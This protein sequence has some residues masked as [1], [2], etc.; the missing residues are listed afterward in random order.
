L[1]Q[2]I[3]SNNIDAR[4]DELLTYAKKMGA[5]AAEVDINIETGYSATARM[6]EAET[7]EYNHDND[8]SIAVYAGQKTGVVSTSDLRP[9]ALHQAVDAALRIAKYTQD[10]PAAGLADK[11]LLAKQVP[12]LEIDFPWALS[13]PEAM[14]LAAECD[15]LGLDYSAKII[16]SDGAT[17][18]SHRSLSAYANSNGFCQH[19]HST[20]HNISSV[21]VGQDGQDMQRD[22]YYYTASD[23]ND[24]PGI[25]QVA[26]LA[27][28]RT[29]QRLNPRQIS[30]GQVPVLFAPEVARGL[31]GHVLSAIHGGALYKKASFLLDKLET[32]IFPSWFSLEEQ[33]HLPKGLGS[34]AFDANGLL[35]YDKFFVEEGIL[36]NYALGIYSA[37]KLKMQSTA[38]AGG[39]HNIIATTGDKDFAAMLKELDTG[40]L[41]TEIVGPGVNTVTGD[42]SRGASGFWVEKGEIQYPFDEVTIAGNLGDIYRNIRCMGNDVDQRGKV[43]C[44][45]IL[46]DGLM[47]A[48]GLA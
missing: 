35:T 29:V 16:N 30:T 47:V 44:G 1:Q 33:P 14:R 32:Q 37:R 31:L 39:V 15:T 46:V 12:Q 28:E 18:S 48:G 41:V 27:A 40:I 26:L 2:A 13:A 17:V 34:S 42:Y 45:S 3:T 22:Y 38:N 6:G 21:L 8:V 43:R 7:L 11:E 19:Y 24:L 25:K 9:E 23:A 5:T 20:R 10:D 36:K 4:L